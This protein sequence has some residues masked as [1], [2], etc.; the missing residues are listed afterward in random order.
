[1][2]TASLP[3]IR[4][5]PELRAEVQSLLGDVETA[6]AFVEASVRASVARRR[7]QAEFV[8]RGLRALAGARLAGDYIEAGAV[9]GK[10]QRKLNAARR[11]AR[12]VSIEGTRTF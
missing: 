10:L 11:G 2:K 4:V 8:A 6:S 1:V 12:R 3:T 5:E 9:I 7:N